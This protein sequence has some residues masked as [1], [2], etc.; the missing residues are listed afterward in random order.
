MYRLETVKAELAEARAVAAFIE[1]VI[2]ES[3]DA[4][5]SE[6]AAFV[7][8]TRTNL[9]KWLSAPEASFHLAARA[10]TDLVGVV[11]VRDYWNLCHLFV[12][13]EFQRRGIGRRLLEAAIQACAERPS[14][15]YVRLNASRNAIDFYKRMGFTEVA[16]A[17]VA[18]RG[19]RFE[20]RL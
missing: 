19:M 5:P 8:N 13:P 14:R 10:G 12:H 11:L 4:T 6:K 17:P 15:G 20:R 1:R 16:D 7:A 3:V 9:D 2:A 18:Y